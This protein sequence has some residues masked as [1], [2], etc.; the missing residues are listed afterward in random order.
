MEYSAD[1]AAMIRKVRALDNTQQNMIRASVDAA[2]SDT[3][4]GGARVSAS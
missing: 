2:Y 3:K 4:K 1:D